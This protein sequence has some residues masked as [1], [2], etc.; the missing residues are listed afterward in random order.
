[1]VSDVSTL[2]EEEV[3]EADL[4]PIPTESPISFDLLLDDDIAAL[5]VIVR[6][7][8]CPEE[9]EEQEEE[10][11]TEE[12]VEGGEEHCYDDTVT[13]F[14]EE[15]SKDKEIKSSSV[16]TT[17]EKRKSVASMDDHFYVNVQKDLNSSAQSVADPAADTISEREKQFFEEDA[18]A[19]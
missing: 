18:D 12:T 17:P 9:D 13:V 19:G 4:Q 15:Q 7:W 16:P 5:E 1:M 6:R 10:E 11:L 14:G 2:T 8:T 3:R